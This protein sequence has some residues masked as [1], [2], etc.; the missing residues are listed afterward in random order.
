M[1]ATSTYAR[2]TTV[3]AESSVAEV[4]RLLRRFGAGDFAAFTSEQ[5]GTAGVVFAREGVSYRMTFR[6]PRPQDFTHSHGGQRR[7]APRAIEEAHQQEV[8]R[9]W[10]SLTLL[11]KAQLVAVTDGLAT[12]EEL[13]LPAALLGSGMTVAEEGVPRL[14]QAVQSGQLGGVDL[15]GL[16][17]PRRAS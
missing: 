14:L 3:R 4:Q 15:L 2:T 13:F 6:L 8:R 11:V 10:R 1:S 16:P 7:R 12:F 9:L 17:E 5:R